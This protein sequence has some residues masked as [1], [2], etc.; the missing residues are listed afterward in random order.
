MILSTSN[1]SSPR[2]IFQLFSGVSGLNMVLSLRESRQEV[3]PLAFDDLF[4]QDLLIEGYNSFY[5]KRIL[6]FSNDS[7]VNYNLNTSILNLLIRIGCQ[8]FPLPYQPRPDELCLSSLIRLSSSFCSCLPERN[9]LGL[10]Y[11]R[12]NIG[13]IELCGVCA[14]SFEYRRRHAD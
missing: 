4:V 3:C 11:F 8:V 6:R 9:R 7:N 2:S 10:F 14:Y 1:S 5:S 13:P 12:F